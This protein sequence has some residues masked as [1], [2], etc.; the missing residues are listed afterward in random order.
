MVTPSRPA[1]PQVDEGVILT[2]RCEFDFM[3]CTTFKIN[4]ELMTIVRIH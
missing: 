3:L 4:E 1:P 2:S